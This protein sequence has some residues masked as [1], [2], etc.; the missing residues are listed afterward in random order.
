MADNPDITAGTASVVAGT[1]AVTGAGTFWST[2]EIRSGDLFASDGYPGAR[3][4]TVNSD[5]SITLRD[6]WRGSSLPAGSSYYIRYQ[7]DG[8]RYAALLA[9]VRKILSLPNLTALS[10]LVGAA[11]RIPIFTGFGTMSTVDKLDL[12]TGVNADKKVATLAARAAYDGEAEGFSVLVANI[13]DGRSAIY[14]KNSPTI[15]DWSPPAYLTGPNGSFQ[16]KGAYSNAT[17]YVAGDVVLQNGSSW[18]ARV[19][20]TGNPPP[21]LPV[22]SNSQWFLLSAAGN[23]FQSKGDYA[24]ATAYVKDDVVLYNNSSWIALQST[25]GNAPP[26][27]PATSNAYWLLIAAKG[28]GDVSGP[29]T[30]LSP[31]KFADATGKLLK[32]A[33]Y[34]FASLSGGWRNKVRN[35]WFDLWDVGIA[36]TSVGYFSDNG[37]ANQHAVGSKTHSRQSFALGQT[38]VPGNPRYFSRTTVTSGGTAAAYSLKQQTIENVFTLSGRQI[39]VKF[40]AKADANRNMGF[41]LSQSFGTGGSPSSAVSVDTRAVALT[42]AWQKFSF[43]INMPSITGKILGTNNDDCF[44]V[45]FWFEA[46]AT[47]HPAMNALIGL[48]S[49]TFDI[50]GVE[51]VEGD[52]TDEPGPLEIR[53]IGTEAL[54]GQRYMHWMD[55]QESAF[56]NF[57]SGFFISNAAA[58]FQLVHPVK[59]RAAPSFFSGGASSFGGTAISQDVPGRDVSRINLSIAGTQGNGANLQAASTTGTFLYFLAE[60]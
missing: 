36:Q 5:T 59:M 22:T 1:K 18:I 58:I 26:A 4:D 28:S 6:N 15:A 2:D 13:G 21:A 44:V 43:T 7:P 55:S 17:A 34:T 56:K 35:G 3:I 32:D 29:A 39:T 31:V 30:S 38:Q 8:S 52:A 48:Q 60:I 20:T 49:G 9:A 53:N 16:S 11:G 23:G 37:W 47:A 12:V 33:G 51:I 42:T 10:G 57:A 25:T 41:I 50:A 24:G 14:F 27:L 46:G 19:S 45:Y 40:Y 54:I